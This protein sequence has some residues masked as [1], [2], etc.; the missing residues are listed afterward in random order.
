M[1]Y[2]LMLYRTHTENEA[3]VIHHLKEKE[4]EM[5]GIMEEKEKLLESMMKER[6]REKS[7]LEEVKE[8][9]ATVM[10]GDR[11]DLSNCTCVIIRCPPNMS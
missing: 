3:N 6:E 7:Q 2:I 4:S 8:F 9:G 1:S 10:S 11:A 5:E